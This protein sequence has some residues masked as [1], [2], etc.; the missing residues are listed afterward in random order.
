[1]VTD[2]KADV[3]KEMNE[4][5]LQQVRELKDEITT[6]STELKDIAGSA[7]ESL[8]IK[9]VGEQIKGSVS[10]IGDSLDLEKA[11]ATDNSKNKTV[12]K[13][14][15]GK[16]SAGKK[17]TAKKIAKKPGPRKKTPAAKKSAARPKSA[18]PGKKTV[19]KKSRAKKETAKI[20]KTT[21]G[22]PARNS[23]H[24]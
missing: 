14:T 2:I 16:K 13:S 4:Y 18:T 1:M 6:A 9:E 20:G 10:E 3:K 17:K 5:D 22:A 12:R 21:A 24:G 19:T 15:G 11:A 7:S 8:G 23:T